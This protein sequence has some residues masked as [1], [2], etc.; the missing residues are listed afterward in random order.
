MRKWWAFRSQFLLGTSFQCEYKHA[1]RPLNQRGLLTFA[2]I[3]NPTNILS[4]R[5]HPMKLIISL[6]ITIYAV[7][8]CG[9]QTN[10]TTRWQEGAAN[11]DQ[12]TINGK[13]FKTVT[14]DG[15]TLS[16]SL[17]EER[18]GTELVYYD[19]FVVYLYAVNASERRIELS[20]DMVTVEAIKPKARQI[21]RETAEH[22]SK[23]IK[24]RSAFAGALG[25]VGASMQTTQSTTTGSANGAIYGPGGTV[26]YSGTGS[27][28]TTS[29]DMEARRRANDQAAVLN[30]SAA[31][32]GAD[33]QFVELKAN[34]LLPKQ[35][36][37]GMLIFDREKKCEE[38]IVRVSVDGKII[39]FPFTWQRKK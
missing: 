14:L 2:E 18:L 25:Q 3:L 9:A 28:T 26:T 5:I 7:Q 35:E 6:L 17:G 23:S 34:T 13:T 32:A 33:L 10:N 36:A 8:V 22:L 29:P 37:G 31:R 19:K 4:E 15:L 21:E 27:S 30:G 24:R 1:V 38:A 20:P 16:V 11:T 39:E 12:L